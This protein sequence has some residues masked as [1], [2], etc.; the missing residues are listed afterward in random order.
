MAAKIKKVFILLLSLCVV[1]GGREILQARGSESEEF[2]RAALFK[3]V[4]EVLVSLRGTYQIIDPLE[5]RVIYE[6]K[7]LSRVSIIP[8]KRGIAVGQQYF[9]LPHLRI[10]PKREITIHTGGKN[11][12]YRGFIDVIVRNNQLTIVNELELEQYVRGVL[13][14]EISHRW[15]LEVMKVQA[16]ATRTYVLYQKAMNEKRDYDVT[17]DIYSQ[18]YGGRSAE[19]YRT[20]IAVNRT[21]GKVLI[22]EGK[23]FPTYFHATC[24]GHTEDAKELWG[25]NLFPLK[26]I[27]CN[28]CALSPH[29]RWRKNFRS[30]D[31]QDK[32][33]RH[34]YTI[35]LIENISVVEKNKSGR[36]R[37]LQITARDGKVITLSGR[38]FREIVGPNEIKS[39]RYDVIMKGYY[40]DAVGGGWGHGVGMC[41]WGA[42][43]LS[44]ER[45]KYPEIL[46]FYYPG[47][48]IV[49]YDKSL[50]EGLLKEEVKR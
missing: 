50:I 7:S 44:K 46:T 8:F 29:Y 9:P 36:I 1:A 19:R 37:K 20:N 14:H 40:F 48:E 25:Q 3:N 27:V 12:R 32:L 16:I 31:I 11:R 15:P 22:F 45:F 5:E 10:Y 30:K 34:G 43:Q 39:N 35:G 41:Q 24:A 6:G 47:A 49:D 13:Y 42:A 23:I 26:G 18:V 33:N 28:Y 38:K 21:K 4:D 2:V 17:S